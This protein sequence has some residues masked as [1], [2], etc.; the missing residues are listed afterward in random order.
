M[1]E[2]R[3]KTKLQYGMNK[4]AILLN[5]YDISPNFKSSYYK[6]LNRFKS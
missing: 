2:V 3:I 5:F 6:N 1:I 4:N